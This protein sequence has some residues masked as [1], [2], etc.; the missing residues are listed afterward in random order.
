M[1][2][3]QKFTISQQG[4]AP[5]GSNGTP[6]HKILQK[7]IYCLI[8]GHDPGNLL[9]PRQPFEVRTGTPD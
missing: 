3:L 9:R 7:P 8:F 5:K 2:N 6:G 4:S 1:H